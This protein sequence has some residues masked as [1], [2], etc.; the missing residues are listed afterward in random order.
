MSFHEVPA[1][2]AELH[3]AEV[4]GEDALGA[5]DL[6]GSLAPGTAIPGQADLL[7]AGIGGHHRRRGRGAGAARVLH[8]RRRAG[9]LLVVEGV[10]K[11]AVMCGV[12]SFK[13]PLSSS[14]AR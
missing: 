12:P 6:V 4:A 11:I 13:L 5:E 1:G 7:V 10:R 3:L 14:A 2:G 8:R 9:D